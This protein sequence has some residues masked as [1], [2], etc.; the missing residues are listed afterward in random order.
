MSKKSNRRLTT[1]KVRGEFK[2]IRR[3]VKG[4]P[5]AEVYQLKKQYLLELEQLANKNLIDI[6]YADETQVSMSPCV[7]Y[8]WQ[9]KDEQVGMPTSKA[10]K[11]N[12]FGM[13]SRKNDFV[14]KT[15]TSS[16]DSQF[17]IEQMESFSFSIHKPTVIVL[18]NAKPHTAANIKERL[19]IWQNR[20]LHLFYLPVYSPHLNL[21]ETLWRKLKYEWLKPE[22][23]L[24]KDVLFYAV[25][26]AFAAIG[27][28]LYIQFSP[29]NYTLN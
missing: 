19:A 22:D 17:M 15:T 4:T 13:I 21:A 25:N 2:R 8:G 28:G 6:Y 18:D 5:L 12:C 14:C 7:P 23:Y 24:T 9:F 27:D 10:G 1:F 20:G 16:I 11:I 29:P 26:R 3:V